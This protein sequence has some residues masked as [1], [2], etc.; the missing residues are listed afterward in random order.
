M[1]LVHVFSVSMLII[2]VG[3]VQ[4][5]QSLLFP[6]FSPLLVV[7]PFSRFFFQ[8]GLCQHVLKSAINISSHLSFKLIYWSVIM[9]ALTQEKILLERDAE[10]FQ[11]CMCRILSKPSLRGFLKSH[12]T[13]QV[14]IVPHEVW[15]MMKCF[16]VNHKHT[17]K[18]VYSSQFSRETVSELWPIRSSGPHFLHG[19]FLTTVWIS[20]WALFFFLLIPLGVFLNM[21]EMV[22]PKRMYCF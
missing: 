19:N 21:A 5:L 20:S 7:F 14:Q 17:E 12:H 6:H 1:C 10:E 4:Q 11:C 15:K 3:I 2:K 18:H 8:C 22:C 9:V 13:V 16:A